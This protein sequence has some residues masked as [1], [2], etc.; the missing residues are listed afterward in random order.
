MGETGIASVSYV[1]DTSE[2]VYFQTPGHIGHKKLIELEQ[3]YLA[4]DKVR[5]N[6]FLSG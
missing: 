3:F 1:S 4:A 5:L 6:C 2:K